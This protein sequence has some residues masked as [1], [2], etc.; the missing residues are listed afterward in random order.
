MT[1]GLAAA[2]PGITL[3]RFVAAGILAVMALAAPKPARAGRLGPDVIALFPKDVGEFAY[4]D[5]KKARTLKWFP[6]L[7]EQMLPERFRQFEKFLAS[8][9]VD[10]NSQVDELAWALVAASMSGKPED[11]ASSAAAVPTGEE[12]VGVALGN[13]N[14]GSTES[15]FKQ[16]KLPTFKARGYTMYAFGTGSGPN[17][18]FFLFIDSNTAAFGHRTLLEKMIEV[19]FGTE[20]GLLHNDKFFPLIN[21][22]NGSGVVWAVLNPAYTRL[23]MQQLAPEVEQFPEAA[24]L[25]ARM[26][27]MIINVDASSGVDGK[28]QAVCGSSEDANTLGQLLQAGFLYK[29]YQAQKDNPD[30]AQLLDQARV[31][32]AGD[33][34]MLSMSLSDDQITALIRKNTFALKM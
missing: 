29:R 15:Y 9:G 27:N 1:S 20:E 22:A 2:R 25:V 34:V 13:F 26:Q 23:A 24:K 12:V 5:L 7:Q 14:P 19:R 18:L 30:L 6:Q 4:A 31:T 8:A 32:P 33:R 17:D 21:E 16:Q 10:P 11:A 28:F 3:G